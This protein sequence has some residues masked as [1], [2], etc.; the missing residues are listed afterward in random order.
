MVSTGS[1]QANTLGLTERAAQRPSDRPRRLLEGRALSTAL[2][3]IEAR[4]VALNYQRPELRMVDGQTQERLEALGNLISQ[5]SCSP[6]S[7]SKGPLTVVK[8]NEIL[9]EMILAVEKFEEQEPTRPPDDQTIDQFQK[10]L[11][12]LPLYDLAELVYLGAWGKSDRKPPN[13]DW[14]V[15]EA[16]REMTARPGRIQLGAAWWGIGVAL[17]MAFVAVVVA[18]L[19]IPLEKSVFCWLFSSACE[20]KTAMVVP[21]AD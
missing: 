10:K 5:K 3:A 8:V 12:E 17:T 4:L 19:A 18:V 20:S 15:V 7:I 6:P 14:K 16:N 11:K 13:S 1:G 21:D 9:R 2:D